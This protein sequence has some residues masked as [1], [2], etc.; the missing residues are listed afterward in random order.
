MKLYHGSN[1]PVEI[2][3]I[4]LSKKAKDF[5]TGFYL[6]S[7]FE[8]TKKWANNVTNRRGVGKPLV[9]VYE[10]NEKYLKNLDILEFKYPN[11]EW[12]HFISDNR[13]N[14]YVGKDYDIVIGPV[15]NDNTMPVINLFVSGFLDEEYAIKMLLPQKL[16]DQYT[17][18]TEKALQLLKFTEV[19]PCKK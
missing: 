15:A 14:I 1:V 7:D 13:K 4:L 10:V 9:S 11:N 6:S 19:I 5:G 17:F 16:K 2:P 8:Q 3:K 12:L 18:K